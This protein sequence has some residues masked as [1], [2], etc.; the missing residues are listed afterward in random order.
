MIKRLKQAWKLSK[1]PEVSL[2]ALMEKKQ[3]KAIEDDLSNMGD[4][5]AVFFNGDPTPEE[6][7][8]YERDQEGTLPW[9]KRL[10]N[11]K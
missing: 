1:E 6:T 10:M 7:L 5:Q 11:L 4:G 8:A 3:K 2:L 9:Y